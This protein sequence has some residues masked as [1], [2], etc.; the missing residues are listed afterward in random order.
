MKLRDESGVTLMEVVVTSVIVGLLAAMASFGISTY[1]TNGKKRVVQG[2]LATLKT[3]VRLYILDNGFPGTFTGQELVSSGYLPELLPD[4]FAK[5]SANYVL[6][7]KGNKIYIGSRGPDG[8]VDY[9][10]SGNRD[11]IFVYLP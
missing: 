8:A 3:A 1:L 10:E 9:G 5:D 11:D 6:E 4:P 2:D 7:I